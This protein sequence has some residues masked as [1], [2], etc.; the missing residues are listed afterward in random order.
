LQPSFTPAPFHSVH[1]GDFIDH[2]LLKADARQV[3]IEK[4][5]AEAVAHRFKAVCVNSCRV[6]EAVKV[7]K[8]YHHFSAYKSLIQY[9]L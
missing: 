2:T 5:C 9:M 6:K 3:D 7:S 1:L 8:I 4:L